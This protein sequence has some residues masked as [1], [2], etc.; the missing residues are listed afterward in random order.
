MPQSYLLELTGDKIDMATE[1][2]NL[3]P[4]GNFFWKTVTFLISAINSCS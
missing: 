4:G 1:T 2:S 3:L